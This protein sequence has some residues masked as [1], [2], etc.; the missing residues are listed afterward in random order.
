MNCARDLFDL[1]SYQQLLDESWSR[2]QAQL[3]EKEGGREGER[4]REG[5]ERERERFN[6]ELASKHYT[7]DH[8]ILYNNIIIPHNGTTNPSCIIKFICAALVYSDIVILWI[9]AHQEH[10]VLQKSLKLYWINST[11]NHT[12]ANRCSG[13]FFFFLHIVKCSK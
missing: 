5:R 3:R 11:T 12:K 13:L 4:K 10:S 1:S 9:S 2:N 6:T 7:V 8:C